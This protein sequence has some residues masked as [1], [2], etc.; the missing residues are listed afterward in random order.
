MLDS[1]TGLKVSQI[2]FRRPKEDRTRH[3]SALLDHLLLSFAIHFSDWWPLDKLQEIPTSLRA[4]QGDPDLSR[5]REPSKRPWPV[6]RC[7][8]PWYQW[9][10]RKQTEETIFAKP[11]LGFSFKLIPQ[12]CTSLATVVWNTLAYAKPDTYGWNDESNPSFLSPSRLET[13]TYR[14]TPRVI[15]V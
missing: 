7:C 11:H 13:G 14:T 15:V 1:S 10:W 12:P 8:S 4:P 3:I 2:D 6:W 9:I 5:A